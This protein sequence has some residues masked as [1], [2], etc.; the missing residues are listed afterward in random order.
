M[1]KGPYITDE[2]KQLIAQVHFEHPDF[3]AK[4]VKVEIDRLFEGKG[5][6]I[7]AIQKELT[8]IN[9]RYREIGSVQEKFWSLGLLSQPGVPDLSADS[10]PA[11]LAVQADRLK[12]RESPLSVRETK[13]VARLHR[14]TSDF[15][16]LSLWVRLYA[17]L[18]RACEAASV[19]INTTDMDIG[20]ITGQFPIEFFRWVALTH[21]GSDYEKNV[22]GEALLPHVEKILLGHRLESLEFNGKAL[23]WYMYQLG[24]LIVTVR[25]K[26]LSKEAQELLVLRIRE[27]INQ[28]Q[29]DLRQPTEIYEEFDINVKRG[30]NT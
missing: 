6:G 9:R 13:W 12:R 8:K 26:D 29:E 4:E 16:E 3:V 17:A 11:I 2:I 15:I 20:L 18:E 27:F 23:W 7:S 22:V 24:R 30:T 10:I 19:S 28:H 25:W 1:A 21:I 5:P 14:L